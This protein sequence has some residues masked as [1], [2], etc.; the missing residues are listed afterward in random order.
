MKAATLVTASHLEIWLPKG[1]ASNKTSTLAS[2]TRQRQPLKRH[3]A[4]IYEKQCIGTS[5][6][7]HHVGFSDP[8]A[9]C[10]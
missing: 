6:K 2:S 4:A 1:V 7:S 8:F 10:A 9:R 3:M 5:T